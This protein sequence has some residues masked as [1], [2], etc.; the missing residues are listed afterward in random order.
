MSAGA[1]GSTAMYQ[2]Y[3]C[4]CSPKRLGNGVGGNLQATNSP[5]RCKSGLHFALTSLILPMAHL[6]LT[7]TVQAFWLCSK[8]RTNRRCCLL[9]G[10]I[11]DWANGQWSGVA[12]SI[13]SWMFMYQMLWVIKI[14]HCH[15]TL[16]LCW[17]A[18]LFLMIPLTSMGLNRGSTII[19]LYLR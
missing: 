7:S 3:I 10:N 6:R 8:Y 5:T 18:H 19:R 1:F 15:W 4:D 9:R 13:S 14:F 17:F 16:H 12:S 11:T 2:R